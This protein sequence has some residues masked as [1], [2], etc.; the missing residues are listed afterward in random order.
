M[1][2]DPGGLKTCG[3]GSPTL[4]LAV[5]VFSVNAF[6]LFLTLGGSAAEP[7]RVYF[8]DARALGLFPRQKRALQEPLNNLTIAPDM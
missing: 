5:M 3:S 6:N 8:C 4:I 2:P 7:E 1:D